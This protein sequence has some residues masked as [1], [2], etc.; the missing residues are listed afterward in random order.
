MLKRVFKYI[1]VAA[2]ICYL[3]FT[4]FVIPVLNET[5]RCNNVLVHI[6]NN[7]YET[8]TDE[9]IIGLINDAGLSPEHKKMD[10][11]ACGEIEQ[12]LNEISLIKECQVY[13]GNKDFIN[14]R[15]DCRK[16]IIKVYD[17]ENKTYCID[18]EGYM[19]RGIKSALHI[20]VATGNIVDSMAT[21]EL[22][23]FATAIQESE[24][25]TAQIEQIHFKENNEVIVVPRVGDH[26]IE[27]GH[28]E[29]IEQKL[30]KLYSF[31]HEGM[32]KIGW[33]KYSKINIEFG[34]KVICTKRD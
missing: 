16:P 32:N 29:N 24:F 21:K 33:N 19:I 7:E 14:I 15:V 34:D 4:V 20:P 8:I 5:G 18:E 28:A 23:E 10:S 17:K 2:V 3:L 9:E 1:F 12:Y 22:K 30:E 25:W 13:K 11:I 31:Y 26:I 27:M 6:H